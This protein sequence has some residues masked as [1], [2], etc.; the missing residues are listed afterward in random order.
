VLGAAERNVV[1]LG[2]GKIV[3]VSLENVLRCGECPYCSPR[4]EPTKAGENN[5]EYNHPLPPKKT[6][7]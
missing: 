4:A 7:M 5:R 1:G 2:S 3:H 6:Q